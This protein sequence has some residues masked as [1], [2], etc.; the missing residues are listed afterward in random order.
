MI[1]LLFVEDDEMLAYVV[2]SG[3]ELLEKE[4]DI[5]HAS[6]GKEA[7]E[8]Y[9]TFAP[10]VVVSDIE[11][12][13][14]NGFE[15]ART[16]RQ[17]DDNVVIILASG[18]VSPQHVLSGYE[19]NIDEYVKKPYLADELHSRIQ[20]IL[21]R[22][23]QNQTADLPTDNTPQNSVKIG[24]YI[25]DIEN[26]VLIFNNKTKQKLTLREADILTLLCENQNRIVKR[27]DILER[28]WAEDDPEFSSRSLDVFITKL[29]KY[30]AND[31]NIEIVNE[32]GRGLRLRVG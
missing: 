26:G 4:Y 20:A 21:R 2:K 19:I 5:R 18:L 15:L 29:R 14:M 8:I 13:V 30:L 11:M 24:K 22:V 12:P 32:R 7:L 6:N 23:R 31:T 3:L 9:K 25:F 10:D 16:I 17:T 28:F 1:K 27:S